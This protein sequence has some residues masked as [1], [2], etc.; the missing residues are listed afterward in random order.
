MFLSEL[1]FKLLVSDSTV[2]YS[3]DN[4]IFIM[5]FVNN[6]LFIGFNINEINIIKRKITKEYIIKDRSPVVYFFGV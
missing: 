6:C 3:L 5:M 2:F 4:G 1:S